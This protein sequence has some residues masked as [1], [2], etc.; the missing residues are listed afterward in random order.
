MS[1]VNLN[2][3]LAFYSLFLWIPAEV[4]HLQCCL[5]VKWLVPHET[6]AVLGC[7]V[8][9]KQPRPVSH[10]FMQSHICRVHACLAVTCHLHLWQND[11]DLLCATA[12]TWG[13]NWYWSKSRHRKF[14]LERKHFLP[15]LS[16]L[17]PKTFWSR[18]WQ[19]KSCSSFPLFDDYNLPKRDMTMTIKRKHSIWGPHVPVKY[20]VMLECHLTLCCSWY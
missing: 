6:A 18:V 4:V 20:L 8:Y 19:S 16:G 10:H 12:V 1:H 5:V 11:R 3:W 15:L 7:S 13:W 9:T 14:T 2:E 17:E